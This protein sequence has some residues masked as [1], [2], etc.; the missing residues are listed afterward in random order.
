[1][2]ST[3]QQFLVK[4]LVSHY[5]QV[6]PTIIE[7]LK[8]II[9]LIANTFNPRIRPS[10]QDTPIEGEKVKSRGNF[11]KAVAVT[12]IALSTFAI[13]ASLVYASGMTYNQPRN[14]FF[15]D[16]ADPNRVMAT[17]IGSFI[18]LDKLTKING[19]N[20]SII[21]A[22]AKPGAWSGGGFLAGNDKLI[23]VIKKDWKT[24]DKLGT[25][26]IE[27]AKHLELIWD[28]AEI[29]F[30]KNKI[31]LISYNSSLLEGNTIRVEPQQ[32][33][34]ERGDTSGWQNDIFTNRVDGTL[35]E[36][37]I[38]PNN[39]T[40]EEGYCLPLVTH[41]THWGSDLEIKNLKNGEG[42]LVAKGV[43]D[44]IRKYGFYEGGKGNRNYQDY[45]FRY[46]DEHKQKEPEAGTNFYR[47]DPIRLAAVL[48]GHSY[49]AVA[50]VID[51]PC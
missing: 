48:S 2:I 31:K 14:N 43:I 45:E 34:V 17:D 26:H 47:I 13:T 35:E 32:L 1:M 15:L 10:I 42:I 18:D 50:K 5:V 6:L 46:S 44:Y 39:S 21:E 36:I 9:P 40:G 38:P 33:R 25:S 11:I 22:R 24:V 12:A 19:V 29:E 28:L 27:L 8:F 20:V 51:Q 7:K 49:C 37:C 4:P 30:N 3:S 16:K 41:P 23:D